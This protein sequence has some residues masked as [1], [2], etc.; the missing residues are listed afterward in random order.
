MDVQT[1]IESGVL[2]LYVMQALPDAERKEVESLAAQYP[3][4]QAE[5]ERI[6]AALQQYALDYA[7]VPRPDLKR[8]I[9]SN[10]RDLPKKE[11]P[12]VPFWRWAI[13]AAFILAIGSSIWLY[14]KWNE[15]KQA[16]A[17][18]TVA[19]QTLEQDCQLTRQQLNILT[20]PQTRAIVLNGLPI[21]P[22]SRVKIYWN[23]EHEATFLSIESLPPAPDG[24][25]YQL[26]SLIG[27]NPTSAGVF[28]RNIGVLQIMESVAN[29]EQF[30]VTLEPAGGSATPT[31]DRMYVAGK[32]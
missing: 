7:Q 21:A 5:I 31:L 26:W 2:E 9:F 29:A 24:M 4:I 10:I 15:S 6:E 20:N 1:Y 28:D 16:F 12:V 17:Q 19:Q 25:Q 8:E 30:A 23:A 14:S 11:T 32:V 3:E 18:L 27:D 22:E 13:A